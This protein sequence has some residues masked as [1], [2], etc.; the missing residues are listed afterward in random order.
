MTLADAHNAHAEAIKK[1]EQGIDPGAVTVAERKEDRKAPTIAD[2]VAEYLEKWAKPRK[3]SW[4]VDKRILEKDV[5]VDPV[6]LDTVLGD[7]Q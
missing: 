1:L 4:M 5:E 2:L 3:R 6:F 7:N